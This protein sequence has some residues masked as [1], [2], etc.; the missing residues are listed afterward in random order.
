MRMR[1]V[2]IS[3]GAFILAGIFALIFLAL[4]VS[5][6]SLSDNRQAYTLY[7]NFDNVG[8]LNNRT[9]VAIGGVTVGRVTGISLDKKTYMARVAMNIED[10]V[11]NI[12]VDSTASILTAG[13]LGEQYVSIG[14][15]GED[16][17]MKPGDTFS[18]TQSALV[19][20]NLIGKFLFNDSGSKE[21]ETAVHHNT[22]TAPGG[23]SF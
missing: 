23:D 2:E 9:R 22:G 11:D 5:G 21:T 14:I 10:S 16:R 18:D 15:G 20:E 8:S 19:L 13:L 12:P 4:R 7:A 6:L 17:Y 1:T 3:V